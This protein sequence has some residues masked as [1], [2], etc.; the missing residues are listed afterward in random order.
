MNKYTN[1]MLLPEPLFRAICQDDYSPGESDISTTSLS[2]PSRI[3]A[4]RKL[5]KDEITEDASDRI[6][7][8]MGSIGH[9]IAEKNSNDPRYISEVRYYVDFD[10]VKIGGQID[11]YD[12]E[13][14]TLYDYKVCSYWVAKEGVKPEWQEQAS[15]NRLLLERNGIPVHQVKYITI[16]RD[17][18]K[19]RAGQNGMTDGQVMVWGINPWPLDQTEAWIRSRIASHHAALKALPECTKEDRW[20]KDDQW[21]LM[22]KGQKRAVK[23]YDTEAEAAT[24]IKTVSAGYLEKRPGESTRCKDYCQVSAFCT[25]YQALLKANGE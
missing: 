3:W 19:G 20:A 14:C 7:A 8:F 24:A 25:Q 4:L 16:F 2:V 5:H 6:W 15:V 23:L 12:R 21:A 13:T 18:S 9:R 11:L 1:K 17:W 22:K 10:G